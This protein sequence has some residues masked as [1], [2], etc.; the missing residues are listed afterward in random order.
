MELARETPSKVRRTPALTAQAREIFEHELLVYGG[1]EPGG[2][3]PRIAEETGL[4]LEQARDA[5]FAES[6]DAWRRGLDDV[7]RSQDHDADD[8]AGG[9]D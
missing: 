5:I 8:D 6:A 2:T 3:I 7:K 4:D 9:D 1:W